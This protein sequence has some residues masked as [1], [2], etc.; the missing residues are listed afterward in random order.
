MVM[1]LWMLRWGV[2]GRIER[3][4]TSCFTDEMKR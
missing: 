1:M 4:G 2:M 3:L